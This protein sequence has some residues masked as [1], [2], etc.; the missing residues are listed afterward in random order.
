LTASPKSSDVCHDSLACSHAS[1]ISGPEQLA[2]TESA[3]SNKALVVRARNPN[4]C[5][6]DYEP[7]IVFSHGAWPSHA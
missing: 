4:T 6:F 1:N 3:S 5:V 7:G 2:P